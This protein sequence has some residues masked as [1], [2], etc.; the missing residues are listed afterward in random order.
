MS[1]FR[2]YSQKKPGFDVE[3]RGLCAALR[4]QLGVQGLQAVAILNRYDADQIDPA[5]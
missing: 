4:E 5:V 3:A 1:V 2:C